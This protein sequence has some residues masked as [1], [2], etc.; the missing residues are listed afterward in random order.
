MNIFDHPYDMHNNNI[1]P[2]LIMIYS[3]AISNQGSR[4]DG[5]NG[6]GSDWN[7]A[8]I[9]L[10]SHHLLKSNSNNGPSPGRFNLESDGRYTCSS[11]PPIVSW[12]GGCCSL[13]RVPSM[14]SNNAPPPPEHSF[15]SDWNNGPSPGHLNL[16]SGVLVSY[17]WFPGRCHI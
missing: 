11:L 8:H 3:S 14:T 16:V 5:N 17:L 2:H 15:K 12:W 10:P 4:P 9:L 1:Q 13:P 7:S 6:P